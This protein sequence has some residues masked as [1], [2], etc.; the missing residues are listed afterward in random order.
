[1]R[2]TSPLVL[3]LL[4]VLCLG[5]GDGSGSQP[6]RAEV[7]RQA[8]LAERELATLAELLRRGDYETVAQKARLVTNSMAR[9]SAARLAAVAADTLAAR[10]AART[11]FLRDSLRAHGRTLP[12]TDVAGNLDTYEFLATLDPADTA[13]AGRLAQYRREAARQ[14]AA[15]QAAAQQAAAKQAAA[16]LER[17]RTIRL[18]AVYRSEEDVKVALTAIA[19]ARMRNR[20]DVRDRRAFEALVVCVPPSGSRVA[21]M[22]RSAITNPSTTVF[23][24]TVTSGE[25]AGCRGYVDGSDVQVGP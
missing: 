4:L 7:A 20:G 5:C 17:G 9:D 23:Q 10:K 14:A 6:S 18:T 19:L 13:V 21:I 22:S 11:A 25:S 24:V 15:G 12:A 16:A 8:R 2:P 1:M 3:G